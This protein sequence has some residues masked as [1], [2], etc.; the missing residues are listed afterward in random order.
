[1]CNAVMLYPLFSYDD[2]FGSIRIFEFPKGSGDLYAYACIFP[3]VR[4]ACI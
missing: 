3:K 1:V 4:K 2:M